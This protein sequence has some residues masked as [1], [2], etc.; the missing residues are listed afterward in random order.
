MPGGSSSS[1]AA[2]GSGQAT[3]SAGRP[4]GRRQIAS[5]AGDST[6]P[7]APVS[8]MP[9]RLPSFRGAPPPGRRPAGG[10]SGM[11]VAVDRRRGAPGLR[12]R[13]L[14]RLADARQDVQGEDCA[15]ARSPGRRSPPDGAPAPRRRRHNPARRGCGS[16]PRARAGSRKA[17]GRSARPRYRPNRCR[18]GGG[19]RR[20]GRRELESQLVVARRHQ[21]EAGPRAGEA[22]LGAGPHPLAA[23]HRPAAHG[24]AACS[25]N[26]SSSQNSTWQTIAA[27]KREP[28]RMPRKTAFG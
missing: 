15:A 12:G 3:A 26:P 10:G 16:A 2:R 13:Q 27:W 7:I 18:A 19:P 21:L 23:A 17:P 24:A 28:P 8:A 9:S 6:T 22:D 4:K 14:G 25:A 11:R 1:C 20:R 5:C